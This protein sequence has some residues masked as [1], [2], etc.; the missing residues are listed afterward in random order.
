MQLFSCV[1]DR[2]RTRI[3]GTGIRENAVGGC[4][5]T[6][7][8]LVIS[9]FQQFSQLAFVGEN[10]SVLLKSVGEKNPLFLFCLFLAAFKDRYFNVMRFKFSAYRGYVLTNNF[11]IL[12]VL[13]VVV[14]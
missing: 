2:N 7:L 3:S 8:A 4:L 1:P 5:P 14:E 6:P 12:G 11:D 10:V 13:C 9:G